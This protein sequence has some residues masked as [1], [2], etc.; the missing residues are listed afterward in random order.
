MLVPSASV[1][2]AAN[3]PGVD[4]NK[5]ASVGVG[6]GSHM[7]SQS[8]AFGGS[9]RFSS[10]GVLRGSLSTGMNSG[11]KPVVGFGAGWSW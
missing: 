6:L 1:V 8:L 11:S 3:I 2:A 10:N 7:G 9:Y 5:T 4:T